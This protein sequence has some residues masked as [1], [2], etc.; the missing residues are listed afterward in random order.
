[1]VCNNSGF[2]DANLFTIVD[3]DVFPEFIKKIFDRL[4]D[5][6]LFEN[7]PFQVSINYYIS[8]QYQIIVRI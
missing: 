2:V 5:Q 4:L 7:T 1:M 6:R 3:P 8:K